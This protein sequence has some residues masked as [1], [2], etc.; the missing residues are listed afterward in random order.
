LTWLNLT[1]TNVT[2]AGIKELA[3][4]TRLH[5]LSVADT[6]V[7]AAGVQELQKALPKCEIMR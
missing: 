2:D 6:W 1:G 5:T 3:A 4:L 7:T